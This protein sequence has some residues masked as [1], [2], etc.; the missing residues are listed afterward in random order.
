MGETIAVGGFEFLVENR[1]AGEDGGPSLQVLSTVD[2]VKVQLLRFDMFHKDPHYHYA[3]T[4]QN[5]QYHVD[6][7]TVDDG[8][9]WVMRLLSNKFPQAVTKAGYEERAAQGERDA[10]RQALPE[11]ERR[12]RAQG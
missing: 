1:R 5:I 2:G 8:I 7:L 12:W 4:G 11:I 10:V 6:P 9:S 3:P